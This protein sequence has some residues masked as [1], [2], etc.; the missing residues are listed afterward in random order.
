MGVA[1]GLESAA[2]ADVPPTRGRERGVGRVLKEMLQ[3]QG[4]TESSTQLLVQASM[5][6]ALESLTG[7][8]SREPETLEDL[9]LGSGRDEEDASKLGSTSKGTTNLT[10]WHTQIERNPALFVETFNTQV[11]KTLGVDITGARWSL[12]QYAAT[13]INF[14][15][16]DTH[17][18]SFYMM[19]ALHSHM[20]RG[21]HALAL[22]KVCQF[23]KALEQSV[24]QDGSWKSAWLLSGL[25]DPRPPPGGYQQGLSHSA[26]LGLTAAY[27]KELKLLEEAAKKE[28]D[29]PSGAPG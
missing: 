9:L 13:R 16:L 8:N 28:S 29:P 25:P 11:I 5:L 1:A 20:M 6:E 23:M 24:Q 4:V 18:K 7:R 21:E 10:R 17:E 26:E 19:A 2:A 3:Q 12:Q 15:R 22:A 14:R 27:L